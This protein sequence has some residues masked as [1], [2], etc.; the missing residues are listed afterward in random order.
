[1]NN[2]ERLQ[3]YLLTSV[4]LANK[5]KVVRNA[6]K[7]YARTKAQPA[8]E[9]VIRAKSI[10]EDA[11]I[12][13]TA[14]GVHP[15]VRSFVKDEDLQQTSILDQIRQYRPAET[16]FEFKKMGHKMTAA[17]DI[18]QKR[19][20]LVG[21]VIGKR[22]EQKK[23]QQQQQQQQVKPNPEQQK[24]TLTNESVEIADYFPQTE[25]TGVVG[26]NKRFRDEAHYISHTRQDHY[27]E[28]ALSIDAGV[29]A[30]QREANQAQM[31]IVADDMGQLSKQRSALR[32]DKKKKQ[33]VR[34]TVGSDNRKRIRTEN[35]TL[36][37]ASFKTNR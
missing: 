17:N 7:M 3:H 20:G 16:I 33:F 6:M 15:L 27:G 2:S 28:K 36:L 21:E 32:W 14:M 37:P 34:N 31:D 5:Q 23:Q 18:M 25:S 12:G 24:P 11:P 13:S 29:S 19:R 22:R 35:G 10:F 4:D 26:K 1:M 30:F 8:K 9:S